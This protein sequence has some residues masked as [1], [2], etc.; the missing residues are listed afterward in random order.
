MAG[1]GV[2]RK[3]VIY[4]RLSVEHDESVSIDRQ[5]EACRRY[6]EARAWDVVAVKVD[7]GVSATHRK[8]ETR[9]GWREVLELSDPYDVVIVWKIDR[10]ARRVIDFNHAHEA[11]VQRGASVA[12]VEQSIDMTTAYGKA[13]A[14]IIAVF[15][16]LEAAEISSRVK[17]ARDYLLRVGR[18][19]GG[20][21]PYGY[22]KRAN[23]S[24]PGFVLAKDPETIRF[25]EGMVAHAR[26]GETV[27]SITKWLDAVGA[28]LPTASQKSR[29]RQGWNYSTVER[30]LRSPIL[31]GKIPYNPGN[32]SKNR[33]EDV[34]RD[35]SGLPV[36]DE[37]L[38]VLG[39]EDHR[40]LIDL[41]DNRESPQARPRAVRGTTPSLLSGLAT[42]GAC[43]RTMYRGTASGRPVLTCPGCYQTIS[44]RQLTSVIAE[45]LLAERGTR[46]TGPIF[47]QPTEDHVALADIEEAI[48]DV[49][50]KMRRDDV[51]APSLLDQLNGLKELRRKTR[52]AVVVVKPRIP[53]YG[54][55]VHAA[56]S[57]GRQREALMSQLESLVIVRGKVG[58]YMDP[59]RVKIAWKADVAIDEDATGQDDAADAAQELRWDP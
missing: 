48:R 41:L 46:S 49:T 16:E 37:S 11:L 22:I 14:Q 45:R 34:L 17:S 15:A 56:W 4:A 44:L 40:A 21:V 7:S 43:Q 59:K 2:V 25:V 5:T 47:P 51:D 27:Y 23:P 1:Q 58:R 20:T 29:K 36:I 38:Q 53:R 26:D 28:P 12:A 35:E 9:T 30:I 3:A 39:T 8:P 18:L 19:P 24:G 50:S 10:L 54:E 52:S 57:A 31:S 6:A 42:C 32:R 33:G 13:M 55:T